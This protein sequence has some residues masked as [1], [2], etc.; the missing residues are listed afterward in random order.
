MERDDCSILR[1][2]S[3]L[4]E[5]K[6]LRTLPSVGYVRISNI[7]GKGFAQIKSGFVVL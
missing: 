4:K 6:M 3:S 7:L 2:G 5:A 1:T